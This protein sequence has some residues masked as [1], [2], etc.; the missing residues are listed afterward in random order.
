MGQRKIATPLT[1]VGPVS[2]PGHCYPPHP[3]EA[4]IQCLN[5][6]HHANISL[7]MR[8][9][10]LHSTEEAER[11]KGECSGGK[12]LLPALQPQLC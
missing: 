8:K 3:L 5:T 4:S 6:R 9:T 2:S 12:Q 7:K 1:P 10:G 11:V